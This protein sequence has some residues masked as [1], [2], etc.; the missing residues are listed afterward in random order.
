MNPSPRTA[1]LGLAAVAALA[2]PA[3][4]TL[5]A[6]RDRVVN[7]EYTTAGGVADVIGGDTNVQ[8]KQL[9]AA[10]IYTRREEV[11]IAA[12]LTDRTGL[13]VAADLVQDTDGDGMPD[14]TLAS[15]CGRTTKPVKLKKRGAA[16]LVHIL[17]GACGAGASAPTTGVV[18]ARLSKK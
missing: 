10:T 16:V 15:F 9:G 17:A 3:S 6:A 5:S 14:V 12:T 1:W 13:P 18:S 7:A 4:A 2:S 11:T 8:G